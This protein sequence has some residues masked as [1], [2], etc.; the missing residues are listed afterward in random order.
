MPILSVCFMLSYPRALGLK[1][2]AHPGDIMKLFCAFR[3]VP[4]GVSTP[5]GVNHTQVSELSRAFS[6]DL[7]LQQPKSGSPPPG[8]PSPGVP[9]HPEPCPGRAGHEDL[10]ANVQKDPHP[11]AADGARESKL[12]VVCRW[13][14]T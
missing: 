1:D 7:S 3:F 14:T 12:S 13:C 10:L 9:S 8:P 4:T 5:L 6:Q 2:C 11:I